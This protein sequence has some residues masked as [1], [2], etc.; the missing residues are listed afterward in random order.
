VDLLGPA[1]K[2][3]NELTGIPSFDKPDYSE[4]FAEEKEILQN[5]KKIFLMVAGSAVQKFGAKLEEEQQ[6]LLA[7]ADILIEIYMAESSL[8]RT[9]KN[10]KR[11]GEDTQKEQIAMSKLYLYHA[12]DII[13]AKAKEGIISFAQGDEQRMM[14]M[15]LK[16]F[17]KYQNQPNVIE[18]RN[19]IAEK[20]TSENK[21]AF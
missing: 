9:E 14:L 17:T 2:V 3:G 12:V 7:S 8:L 21:Y 5:L 16:R 6:L 18:L 15:G 11:F 10:A 20:L 1:T 13:N 4:L 19:I